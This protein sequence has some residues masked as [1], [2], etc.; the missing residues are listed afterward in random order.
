MD[1]KQLIKIIDF[2]QKSAKENA[3]FHRALVD[4]IDVKSGEIVDIVGPRRSGKSSVLKLLMRSLR[5]E[6]WLYINFEDP[7]F[8]DNNTPQIIEELIET[9]EQYYSSKLKYL[10][11]DE[12]QNI[13]H[14]EKVIRKLRD[15]SRYK[16]FV[17][18]SSSKLLSRELSSLLTGRHLSYNLMP[19]NFREYLSFKKINLKSEKDFILQEMKIA[20]YFDRYL[21]LGGF[22]KIVLEEN[23]ELLKQY[24]FDI[25]EKDIVGRYDIRQ[26]N[27]LEKMG[28]YLLSGAGKV[29][30]IASV[31]RAF[32]VSFQAASN[33]LEYFKDA[34]LVFE[35][36]Q[37]SYSLKR[38]QK[39][40]KKIY[41]VDTGLANAVSFRF[42]EDYG[43]MLENCVF[44]HLC[45]FF[46]E[47][48]YYK[49]KSDLEVDFFVKKGNQ[50][51]ELIQVCAD[52]S[53]EKTK[54][55]EI[56]ALVEAIT[57]LGLSSALILT[58]YYRDT[59]KV[60]NYT[61]KVIPVSEWVLGRTFR[62]TA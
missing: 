46:E 13:K 51:P 22:P 12:I 7:F 54:K 8:I 28:L 2:W 4:K 42:S 29:L 3:L 61:I 14:W 55:R 25:L 47:V 10:F 56:K 21:K 35:V 27:V 34:F 40:L 53:E 43:R 32:D 38:Q 41:A 59:V 18:G 23:E 62:A 57:E 45:Q 24:Y 9:Y 44:L 26:K 50:K 37:F 17:S 30:S 33:Y 31:E 5:E 16:I 1:K 58:G 20:R 52:L 49:T 39:S 36:P 48:Y 15:G 11:F 6:S 19:L 60:N